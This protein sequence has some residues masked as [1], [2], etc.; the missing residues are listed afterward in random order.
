[1]LKTIKQITEEEFSLPD[2]SKRTRNHPYPEARAIYY[3]VSKKIKPKFS[4]DRI[5]K[6]MGNRDH[7]TAMYGVRALKDTYLRDREFRDLHRK[8]MD[9][10]N[11]L[12]YGITERF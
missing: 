10:A 7:S 8:I 2:I 3:D 6:F 9:R 1:M 11:E 4:Y 5:A 12:E